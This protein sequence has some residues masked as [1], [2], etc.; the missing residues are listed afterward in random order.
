[1][2]NALKWSALFLLCA[3]VAAVAVFAQTTGGGLQGKVTDASGQ[4][5]IGATIKVTG[6]AVQGF[7]GAATDI[8][9]EYRIPFVPAGKNYTV[10]VEAQG[11]NS[12]VRSGIEIP[13]GTTISLPFQLGQ[14]TSTITVVGSAPIIDTKKTETGATISDTMINNIPQGSRD[15]SSVA[16]MAPGV[17]SSGYNNANPAIGGASAFENSYIVNGMETVSSGIGTNRISMN[18]DFLEATEV[19]TGGIDAEYGGAMGGVVN[20]IT[21]SGGNEFHG[22]LYYYYFSDRLQANQVSFPWALQATPSTGFTEYD[23][24]GFLGGYIIKDKLWFFVNYD[25]NHGR[26]DYSADAT[27]VN[28]TFNGQPSHSWAAGTGY[29]ETNKDPQY[30]FKLT[31]NASQNQKLSLTFMGNQNTFN[32]FSNLNNPYPNSSPYSSQ[33]NNY[34]VNLQWNATWT[35]KFFTEVMVGT[36]RTWSNRTPSAEG[37]ANWMYYYRYGASQFGGFQVI[38]IAASTPNGTYQDLTSWAPSLGFGSYYTSKDYNDQL[39]AKGTLLFNAM[40]RHELSFGVQYYDI[41]Y[42]EDFEYTGPHVTNNDPYDPGYGLTTTS[43]AVVRWQRKTSSPTGFLFRFASWFDDQKKDTAQKYYAYWAQDNW[44]LSD[45]FMVKLGVRWDQ[46]DM[47]G[48]PTAT[49]VND[50]Y[51]G[52][53]GPAAVA[54]MPIKHFKCDDMVAPRVGF[55]WDVAHN[56]KSK[57]YGFYGRYY[58]RVPNDLAIRALSGELGASIYTYDAAGTMPY[59]TSISG[60]T[61]TSLVQYPNGPTTDK[62]HGAYNNEW[63][64]GFQYE[65]AADLTMGARVIYRDLGR[66]IE[67]ISMDGAMSYVVTNPDYWTGLWIPSA[68]YTLFD[69]FGSHGFGYGP[70]NPF[71]EFHDMGANRYRFPEPIRRYT[72]LELTIDKRMSNHWQ[73]GGSYVLSR[74]EGNYEGGYNNDTGQPDP[75][76]SSKYDIPEGMVNSYGLLP[77]D[78]THNLKVYG[79]YSFDWGLD[80]SA[81]FHLASGTPISKYGALIAAVGYG[82]GERLCEPRGSGGRTPTI[83]ALDVGAQYNIKLFKT[84]LGLRMDIFNLTNEQRVTSVDQVWT[85]DDISNAQENPT[86]GYP[87]STQNPRSVRLAVRWTF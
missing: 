34:G 72:A 57:L 29:E 1:M 42:N 25:Y 16:L 46:F 47:T 62:L 10:Q 2:R 41:T 51:Y 40:G 5:V 67:D 56:G 49:I 84:N 63:I 43:G 20:S 26:Y 48:S 58:Q 68:G 9:G 21:K 83:W 44:N 78:R 35:P 71:Y 81:F 22:G 30:A 12:V 15:S 69:Y 39:R 61:G 27:D 87:V 14:G 54:Y 28:L 13:L 38:P 6:P 3:A 50:P 33:L 37:L 74:L 59:Y 18:F 36:R 45:Y 77:D 23:L 75:F 55:T 80:L 79:T 11:F 85:G 17:V 65:V 73:L 76:I 8:N 64:L 7:L 19:K 60:S 24:G 4:P 31:W 86:W 52:N 66:T 82:V 53:P 32:G 70:S